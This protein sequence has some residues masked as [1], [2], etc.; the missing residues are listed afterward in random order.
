M[1]PTRKALLSVATRCLYSRLTVHRRFGDF[2][3]RKL[4]LLAKTLDARPDL[5]SLC[6][7]CDARINSDLWDLADVTSV[8]SML[9]TLHPIDLQL[10]LENRASRDLQRCLHLSRVRRLLFHAAEPNTDRETAALVARLS[11]EASPQITHYAIR[12][13]GLA[14]SSANLEIFELVGFTT[15]RA[16]TYTCLELDKNS[17]SSLYCIVRFA[18]QLES[19]FMNCFRPPDAATFSKWKDSEKQIVE[20]I[21]TAL[22]SV[23]GLFSVGFTYDVS[24]NLSDYRTGYIPPLLLPRAG[25]RSLS[26]GLDELLE[27]VEIIGDAPQLNI[28]ILAV[29]YFTCRF[30][31]RET[32]LERLAEAMSKS[33]LRLYTLKTITLTPVER[34]HPCPERFVAFCKQRWI[35]LRIVNPAARP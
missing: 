17:F 33:N 2:S 26:I 12:L 13:P 23:R 19:L 9:R 34:L 29:P 25:L 28:A 22:G 24:K 15:L 4:D 6:H 8:H 10:Q 21:N 35:K 32:Q 30:T 3:G 7:T 27:D 1:I 31:S 20:P 18:G 16:L 5:A 14:W 11:V